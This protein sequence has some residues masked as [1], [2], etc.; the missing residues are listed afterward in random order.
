M[1]Q[2]EQAELASDGRYSSETA[3]A[4]SRMTYR[5]L[6]Y[7]QRTIRRETAPGSGRVRTFSVGDLMLLTAQRELIELG[8]SQH[9]AWQVINNNNAGQT[10]SQPVSLNIRWSKIAELVTTRLAERTACP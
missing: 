3:L 2:L 8:L 4:V 9:M 10:L 7:F 6:D 5:Q 1:S